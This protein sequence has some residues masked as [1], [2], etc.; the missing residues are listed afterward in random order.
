MYVNWFV[1]WIACHASELFNSNTHMN[2]LNV[3]WM[4]LLDS[5]ELRDAPKDD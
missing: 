2:T 4:H 1:K 5:F 3:G